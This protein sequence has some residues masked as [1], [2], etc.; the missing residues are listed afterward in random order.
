MEIEKIINGDCLEVL[1]DLPDNSIDMVLTSPPYDTLRQYNGFSFDF[2]NIAK[3]LYRIIK[4]GGVIVWVIGDATKDGTESG[5]SFKQA[6]YF[7]NIGFNLYDT[8][9]YRKI[10]YVPLTHNRYEQEFEYMFI[11]SKGRPKTFN[12]IMIPTKTAGTKHNR[13]KSNK[14]EGSSVRNRDET[15]ITKDTKIKGNV[16]DMSVSST[17]YDHPAIFP[18]QL[19]NDHIISWSNDD[20][21]ILDPFAG[22]GT[23]GITAFKNN[24]NFILIEISDKYCEIIQQR[25][26]KELNKDIEMEVW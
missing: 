26:L 13:T 6:L 18:E 17:H 20:D 12:P 22:S 25:F 10:N 15:T 7:K 14:E 16:W 4:L 3:E 19:A 11:F 2:E 21:V 1:K 24:R 5:T 8:M 9:I 23:T